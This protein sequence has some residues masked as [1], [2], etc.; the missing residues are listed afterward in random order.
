MNMGGQ[1]PEALHMANVC[2]RLKNMAW[3]QQKGIHTSTTSEPFCN[4]FWWLKQ[5]VNSRNCTHQ[6]HGASSDTKHTSISQG[7]QTFNCLTWTIALRNLHTFQ[8][9]HRPMYLIHLQHPC[10]SLSY[11]QLEPCE[12]EAKGT[13]QIPACPFHSQPPTQKPSQPHPEYPTPPLNSSTLQKAWCLCCV[14]ACLWYEIPE[15]ATASN[16]T[17]MIH[18]QHLC[19]ICYHLDIIEAL[20]RQFTLAMWWPATSLSITSTK[21][22]CILPANTAT[23]STSCHALIMIGIFPP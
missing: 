4:I 11:C 3:N 16:T 13:D 19:Q 8:R 5:L 21:L 6:F 17:H 20:Q 12:C 18:W 22:R 2:P 9:S 15:R 7:K 1:K 14:V 23:S 10:H